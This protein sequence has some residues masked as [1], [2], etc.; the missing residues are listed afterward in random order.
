MFE[1]ELLKL[2]P[3]MKMCYEYCSFLVKEKSDLHLGPFAKALAWAHIGVALENPGKAIPIFT[4]TAKL[5]E[6]KKGIKRAIAQ[7]LQNIEGRVDIGD[8]TITFWPPYQEE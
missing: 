8:T 7:E 4:S 5:E 1:K 3:N 2:K 6:V